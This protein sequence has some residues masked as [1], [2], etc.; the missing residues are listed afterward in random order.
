LEPA[1][2]LDL[3]DVSLVKRDD[4]VADKKRNSQIK[5]TRDPTGQKTHARPALLFVVMIDAAQRLIQ[6]ATD[7]T[8][9]I[10]LGEH[11]RELVGNQT[12]RFGGGLSPQNPR[13]PCQHRTNQPW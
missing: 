5:T 9:R 6:L 11:I 12:N 3:V 10:E 8:A 13:S 4:F 2:L 7:L 1:G